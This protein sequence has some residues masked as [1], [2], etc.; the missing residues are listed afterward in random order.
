MI[1]LH[2]IS[3]SNYYNMV[4]QA[5]LEKGIEFE[6]VNNPASQESDYK[7]KSPMGKM[8]FI[9]TDG[10]ALCET[11]VILDYLEA[12]K[13][14]PSLYPSDLFAKAKT[15]E[16]MRILEHY[17]E[18]AGRRH[19]GHVFFKGPKSEAAVEEAR[20]VLENGL[21]SLK[22]LCSFGPYLTGADFTYAD[23]VAHNTFGYA[24]MATQAI[25]DWDIIGEVPG[26]GESLAATNARE[27]TKKVDADQAVALEA[28]MAEMG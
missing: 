26:L 10:G 8:P 18:L 11:S 16:I 20:P 13:P 1:K 14:S 3:V 4:K 25:Y 2:G 6:E 21:G 19:Y 7:K 17:V 15:Q 28:F 9:E 22:Q 12:I 27:A 5:M 24:N 23:I